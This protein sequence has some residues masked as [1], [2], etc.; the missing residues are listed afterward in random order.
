VEWVS[1]WVSEH[2]MH[3]YLFDPVVGVWLIL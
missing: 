3:Y 1:E 2:H